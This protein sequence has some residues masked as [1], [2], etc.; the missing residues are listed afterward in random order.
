M[1]YNE[2]IRGPFGLDAAK[3]ATVP[4]HRKVLAVVHHLTAA[5]RLADVLPL[6]ENDRRIQVAYT[7]AP[8]SI[9]H[10][11]LAEYLRALGGLVLPWEQATQLGFDLAIAASHGMLENL[12]APVLT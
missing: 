5:T 8:A 4:G 11:G 3:G 2:W 10:R 12:H 6:L 7:V 9:F 1:S